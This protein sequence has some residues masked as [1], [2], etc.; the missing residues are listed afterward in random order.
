MYIILLALSITWATHA[1]TFSMLDV[2]AIENNILKEQ[3]AHSDEMKNHY[4]KMAVYSEQE[5]ELAVNA[6]ENEKLFT[7]TLKYL[8]DGSRVNYVQSQDLAKEKDHLISSQ[9]LLIEKLESEI[10]NYEVEKYEDLKVQNE[11]DI[12]Y[13]KIE[14]TIDTGKFI[15]V[16]FALGLLI[17]FI[18]YYIQK[19][20]LNRKPKV[21]PEKPTEPLKAVKKEEPKKDSKKPSTTTP[22]KEDKKAPIKTKVSAEDLNDQPAPI[23]PKEPMTF[24]LFIDD[25]KRKKDIKRTLKLE[26][27][28]AKI[29][30]EKKGDIIEEVSIEETN[31]ALFGGVLNK[32]LKTIMKAKKPKET[33]PKPPTST[34][35]T[36]V[37]DVK[38]VKPKAKPS[39]STPPKNNSR[40]RSNDKKSKNEST[41]EQKDK[42]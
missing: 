22:I 40:G 36:K 14:S 20:Y 31:T 15:G 41:P 5:E 17:C 42:K 24:S 11:R 12:K 25:I 38:K 35:E 26:K 32:L 8:L 23:N 9:I 2:T 33:K 1:Q 37:K 13:A 27:E 3:L 6:L 10:A 34:G 28:K 29:L 18:L 16:I 21:K 30:T 39:V 4:Q 19:A 7:E